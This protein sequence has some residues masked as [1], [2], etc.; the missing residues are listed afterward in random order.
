MLGVLFFSAALLTGVGY[1]WIKGGAPER[2]VGISFLIAFTLSLALQQPFAV[3]YLS[4]EWGVLAVDLALLAILVAVALYSDR[5]WPLWV[6]A[7]HGLSTGGHIVRSMEHGI[8]PV[9][10]AI[11]L[12]SWSYPM[13]M[14]LV[15][16]THRHAR[17]A[18]AQGYDLD[19]TPTL[20]ARVS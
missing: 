19:W 13:L 9:A 15:L 2:I 7:L 5:F 1:A 16:G 12:A 17:R 14:L 18:Q 8:E 20:R 4:V 10:Y 3:R 11:L 6:A